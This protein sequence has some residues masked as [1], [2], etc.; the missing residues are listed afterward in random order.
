MLAFEGELDQVDAGELLWYFLEF[1]RVASQL[2]G[3]LMERRTCGGWLA[4]ICR[5]VV[6]CGPILVDLTEVSGG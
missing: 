6:V 1:L 3:R 5:A 2:T 4:Q